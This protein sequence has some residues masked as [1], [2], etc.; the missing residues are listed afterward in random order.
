[1]VY[2][3]TLKTDGL[4]FAIND[5]LVLDSIFKFWRN[6]EKNIFCFVFVFEWVVYKQLC[7][8]PDRSR[9]HLNQYYCH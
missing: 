6:H 8:W 9:H 5:F 7:W 1:M 4:K 2:N 3:R